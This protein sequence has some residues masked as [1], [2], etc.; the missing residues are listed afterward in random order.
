MSMNKLCLIT[1]IAPH[2]RRAIFEE[3]DKEL[4]EQD[5][6]LGNKV[7]EKMNPQHIPA[8]LLL[9]KRHCKINI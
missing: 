1:N 2:Y 6:N 5:K 3:I 9:A 8:S 4:I 7:E